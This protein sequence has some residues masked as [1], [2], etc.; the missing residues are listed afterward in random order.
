MSSMSRCEARLEVLIEIAFR[1]K[2]CESS[3]THLLYVG[4]LT[5]ERACTSPFC[6]L[7]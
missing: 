7:T 4:Q 6:A 3:C 1:L 5:E 2:R